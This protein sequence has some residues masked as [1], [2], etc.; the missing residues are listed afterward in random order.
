MLE[1][2]RIAL[3][4][5]VFSGIPDTPEG[6]VLR[7]LKKLIHLCWDASMTGFHIA[8]GHSL[9]CRGVGYFPKE[10]DFIEMV[11]ESE[12]L[13]EYLHRSYDVSWF[14]SLFQAFMNM[15]LLP[16]DFS[17]D[18]LY[19]VQLDG[20]H[21]WRARVDLVPYTFVN[22]SRTL[23]CGMELEVRI[24][25]H[26]PLSFSDIYPQAFADEVALKQYGLVLVAGLPGSGRTTT[27]MALLGALSSLING[28]HIGTVESPVDY[29]IR[30]EVLGATNA[31]ITQLGIDGG[32]E[33]AWNQGL[34]SLSRRDFNIVYLSEVFPF[35]RSGK[36]L[37]L[38][39]PLIR[40][41][42]SGRHV[43]AT[44]D[45]T[46]FYDVFSRFTLRQTLDDTR[47]ARLA[48]LGVLNGIIVQQLVPV[49]TSQ[50][51]VFPFLH[52]GCM[53]FSDSLK[54]K[55]QDAIFSSVLDDRKLRELF[56]QFEV[57]SGMDTGGSCRSF[58]DSRNAA[59]AEGV[60]PTKLIL[61]GL[62]NNY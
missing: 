28:V 41:S 39:D 38:S 59:I 49:I 35:L 2:M 27:S 62:R 30:P 37:N 48:A 57:M 25:P 12:S 23:D 56:G 51:L 42:G 31:R 29:V 17:R 14:E 11:N 53:V 18:R 47:N 44:M 7:D 24:F 50:G 1:A 60:D 13:K 33:Q 58:A 9:Y 16:R 19:Q 54:L 20:G 3:E 10:Q 8:P 22:S 6:L 36:S 55:M 34:L 61:G 26:T 45:G 15:D 43:V 5:N 46:G 52:S 32:E 21:F 4:E 40:M